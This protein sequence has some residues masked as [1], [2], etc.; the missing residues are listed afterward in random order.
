MTAILFL[1]QWDD[2]EDDDQ[3]DESDKWSLAC[4]TYLYKQIITYIWSNVIKITF[5]IIPQ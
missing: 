4:V 1:P 5:T 2:D 3:D